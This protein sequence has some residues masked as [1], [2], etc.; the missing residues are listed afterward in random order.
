VTTVRVSCPDCAADVAIQS[1]GFLLT[2]FDTGKA[3]YEY[4]CIACHAH[5]VRP[6]DSRARSLLK[7]AQAQTR[8]VHVPLEFLEPKAGKPI[9]AEEIAAFDLE[10][11]EWSAEQESDLRHAR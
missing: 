8:T 4:F 5:V 3:T 6:A 10:F 7:L 9:T 1:T 11:E 2:V